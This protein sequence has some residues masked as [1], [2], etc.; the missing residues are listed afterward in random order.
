M[1]GSDGY[2]VEEYPLLTTAAVALLLFAV[3]FVL[4]R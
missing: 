1:H 3:W 4:R 2:I